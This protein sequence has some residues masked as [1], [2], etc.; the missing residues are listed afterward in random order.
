M[1]EYL[2][3][4]EHYFDRYL[5]ETAGPVADKIDL[6]LGDLEY[7]ESL[8]AKMK[9]HADR[10]ISTNDKIKSEVVESFNEIPIP[11]KASLIKQAFDQ[12]WSVTQLDTS[13]EENG[14]ELSYSVKGDLLI[15][16]L[17]K[18]NIYDL[19]QVNSYM[20]YYNMTPL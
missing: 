9:Y 17:L 10:D 15:R 7:Q 2:K 8:L 14:Y 3:D 6:M 18:T 11:S 16:Y 5:T 1:L 4:I 13:L 19:A 20:T 12:Q